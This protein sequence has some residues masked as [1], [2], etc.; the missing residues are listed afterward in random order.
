MLHDLLHVELGHVVDEV[1]MG[2]SS[3]QEGTVK[4]VLAVLAR[5]TYEMVKDDMIHCC[6]ALVNKWNGTSVKNLSEME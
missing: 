1:G 6:E 4:A 2:I 3:T 5:E